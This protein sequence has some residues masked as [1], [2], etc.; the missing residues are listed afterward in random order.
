MIEQLFVRVDRLMLAVASRKPQETPAGYGSSEM[1]VAARSVSTD[2]RRHGVAGCSRPAESDSWPSIPTGVHMAP[3][4]KAVG[5]K[6]GDRD[7]ALETALAQMERQFGRGAIMPLRD[8]A[9][10]PL[11]GDPARAIAARV[12]PRIRRPPPRPGL[13]AQPARNIRAK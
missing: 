3:N 7:K 2:S 6:A 11:Q 1:S 5:I 4:D 12:A 8:H 9:P 10:A 13:P